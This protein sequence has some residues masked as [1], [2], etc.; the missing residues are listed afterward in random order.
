MRR[1]LVYVAIVAVLAMAILA[2]NPPQRPA[3]VTEV[4]VTFYTVVKAAISGILCLPGT[5]SGQLRVAVLVTSSGFPGNDRSHQESVLYARLAHDLAVAGIASIRYDPPAT[6]GAT[7]P[8][9][10]PPDWEIAN[11]LAAVRYAA[12]R[13]EINPN[14]IFVL[15]YDVA[16]R[17]VPFV[18]RE[19]PN[20]RGM[21]L[22]GADM[23]PAEQI[24]AARTRQELDQQRKS[25]QEI[26]QE[27]ASQNQIFADIRDGKVPADRMIN[28]APAKCWLEWMDRNPIA[29]LRNARSV[30]VVQGG[31]DPEISEESYR[32]LQAALGSSAQ[33][34]WFEGLNHDFA[35][36]QQNETAQS[37]PVD[38]R[39]I[40]VL[41]SWMIMHSPAQQK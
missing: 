36:P 4:P 9:V 25:E 20:L 15:G 31:R 38:Q 28:G 6:P 8:K 1:C 14:A 29:E 32:K 37:S 35:Q 24:V 34:Q 10:A 23:L 19:Y 12:T 13:P 22:M 2:Q 17:L 3:S 27:L 18:A 7:E 39:V 30:L 40:Q 33:F 21:I 5:R 11:A 41:A 16:A 26:S